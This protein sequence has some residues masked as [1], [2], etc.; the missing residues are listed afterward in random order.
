[1]RTPILWLKRHL[2]SW[3]DICTNEDARFRTNNIFTTLMVSFISLFMLVFNLIQG[4]IS[5]IPVLA[6]L[7]ILYGTMFFIQVL[8]S[9][10]QRWASWVFGSMAFGMCHLLL[11]FGGTGGLSFLWIFIVPHI[12]VMVVP[13]KDSFLY[14]GILLSSIAVVLNT[15]LRQFLPYPYS[16]QFCI[17]FP[18]SL[19][20]I[21]GCIYL[22]ETVRFRTQTRLQATARQLTSFAFTD[23]LTGAF[24]RHALTSHFGNINAAPAEGLSFSVMDLDHFK[25]VNDTYGHFVGDEMLKHIVLCIK[26]I[27]PPNAL[28]YRWGG[29]EF[30]LIL[31]TGD[32]CEALPVWERIREL[33]ERT[34][35]ETENG[36][37]T[38]TLSIGGL[39]AFPGSTI[40]QCIELADERLYHAKRSGR[41]CVISDDPPEDSAR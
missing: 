40:H 13:L 23:P 11:Y 24:N 5:M 35:L 38:M 30:L 12:A 17:L 20:F 31:K 32:P 1:M 3:D 14:N 25:A 34:P 29:E 21:T 6:L 39:S 2:N 9:Q 37:V 28:L 41:N 33:V 15:P 27:I 10:Y 16:N 4:N 36:S 18:V 7:A 8:S 26:Q 22:A 19:L